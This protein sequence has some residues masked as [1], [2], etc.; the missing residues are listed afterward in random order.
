MSGE[1]TGRTYLLKVNTGTVGTPVWTEIASKTGL[2]YNPSTNMIDVSST[3][4]FEHV[5]PGRKSE[6]IN[7]DGLF[8]RSGDDFVTLLAAYR[9]NDRIQVYRVDNNVN[10]EWAYAYIES[11]PQDFPSDG[12]ATI[13]L[14]IRIDSDDGND[15]WTAV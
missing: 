8:I 11:M 1:T 2:S 6:V 4:L 12:A 3:G 9:A 13:S 14:T 10:I 7:F 5:L 15:P